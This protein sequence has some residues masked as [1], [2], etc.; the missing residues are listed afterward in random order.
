M[1]PNW[2]LI[3]HEPSEGVLFWGGPLHGEV[4]DGT[5]LRDECKV[6][7]PQRLPLYPEPSDPKGPFV[8]TVTYYRR[9]VGVGWNDTWA[10]SWPVLIYG[11][12]RE[13]L[14]KNLETTM[15]FLL[16]LCRP[17]STASLPKERSYA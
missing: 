9:E 4:V 3:K 17:W 7:I 2:G 11:D 15:N 12:G 10:E 8:Q 5:G 16:W 6:A 13:R 14:L 1:R